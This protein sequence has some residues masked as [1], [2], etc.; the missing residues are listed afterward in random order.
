MSELTAYRFDKYKPFF[1]NP[2]EKDVDK[3]VTNDNRITFILDELE[4]NYNNYLNKNG[5]PPTEGDRDQLKINLSDKSVIPEAMQSELIEYLKDF[6]ARVSGKKMSTKLYTRFPDKSSDDKVDKFILYILDII[7]DT[8]DDSYTFGDVNRIMQLFTSTI[9][10]APWIQRLTNELSRLG[11]HTDS[12]KT[13]FLH[14]TKLGK[15]I[16]YQLIKEET[17]EVSKFLVEGDDGDD[18]NNYYKRDEEGRL[19]RMKEDGTKEHLEITKDFI[20]KNNEKLKR[21]EGVGFKETPDGRCSEYLEKC[22]LGQDIEGCIKFF[23]KQD[24]WENAKEEVKAMNP[25]LALRTLE[26]FKFHTDTGEDGIIRMCD[27][28]TWLKKL[29]GLDVNGPDIKNIRDNTKLIGYLD[30]L[31]SKINKNPSILN[32][33]IDRRNVREP[34]RF[35]STTLYKMGIKPRY[36]DSQPTSW[37]RCA[38]CITNHQNNIRLKLSSPY[39]TT[40]LFGLTGGSMLQMLENKLIEEDKMT[41]GMLK[42]HFLILV[43]QLER[44]GKT[45]ESQDKERIEQLIDDLKQKEIK[46]NKIMIIFEKYKELLVNHNQKDYNKNINVDHMVEFVKKRQHYF[47]RVFKRQ[48]DIMS[49]IRT[50][51]DAVQKELQ[52][53]SLPLRFN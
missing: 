18:E 21:C 19:Y 32:K 6:V 4:K 45:L 24:Y 38:S 27:T 25:L 43:E 39:A 33:E 50:L 11:G 23:K 41:Y 22:L 9:P 37:E 29:P 17:K 28:A 42:T 48:N 51:N 14:N 49:I 20:N 34:D 31:V 7:G 1:N 12:K 26:K 46:L 53:N 8:G 44:N 2:T 13:D 30:M 15:H 16:M 40:K 10:D 5:N 35:K 36:P 52:N 47:E 3:R